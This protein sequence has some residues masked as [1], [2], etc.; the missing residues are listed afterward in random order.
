MPTSFPPHLECN[1]LE[2]IRHGFRDEAK[3]VRPA[4]KPQ[5]RKNRAAYSLNE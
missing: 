4:A 2:S 5:A 3:E 1:K